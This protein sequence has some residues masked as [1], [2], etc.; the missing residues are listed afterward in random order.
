[1]SV[2][3]VEVEGP[4]HFIGGEDCRFVR[5]T[6]VGKWCIS[7]VGDYCPRGV[8]T[9]IGWKRTHETMVFDTTSEDERWQEKDFAAYNADS[10]A[11]AGH[12]AMVEKYLAQP[13]TPDREEP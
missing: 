3:R 11:A 4:G 7:T 6:H 8:Q 12:E 13:S 10:E 5:H 9:T 2:E 1:M